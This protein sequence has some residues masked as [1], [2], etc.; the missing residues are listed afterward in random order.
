MKSWR[1][2]NVPENLH[3]CLFE[4]Q[5]DTSHSRPTAAIGRLSRPSAVRGA[6]SGGQSRCFEALPARVGHRAAEGDA[7]A[8]DDPAVRRRARVS[9]G[10]GWE[11]KQY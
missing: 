11:V 3:W 6:V 9:T 2:Y 8:E 7:V 1:W 5:D 4:K 10:H